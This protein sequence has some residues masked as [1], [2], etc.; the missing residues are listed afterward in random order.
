MNDCVSR[1][2]ISKAKFSWYARYPAKKM[3]ITLFKNLHMYSILKYVTW[4]SNLGNPNIKC[5][6]KIPFSYL[7]SYVHT[8]VAYASLCLKNYI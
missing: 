1:N 7:C 4:G 6:V 2:K 5:N 3:K 8:Y